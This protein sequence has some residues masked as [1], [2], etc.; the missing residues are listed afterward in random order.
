V[1]VALIA[2]FLA[3]LLSIDA[4]KTLFTERARLEQEY[5]VGQM[6]RFGRHVLGALLALDMPFGIGPLQF[7]HYF[8]E[9]THNSFLNAFMSGGWLSGVIYP[10][11]VVLTFAQGLRT[12]FVPTPWRTTYLI[13][14]SAFVGNAAE[15]FIIDSDHW[16]HY[17]LLIGAVWGLALAARS[18]VAVPLPPAVVPGA[19]GRPRLA[20]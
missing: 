16:R 19:A 10:T 13:Y 15:S 20:H 4:V 3:A 14:F 12:V 11:L 17:F 18:P 5:D 9:D 2:L 6:G 7:S 8:P 1:G